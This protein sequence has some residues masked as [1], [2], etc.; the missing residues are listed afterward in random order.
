MRL[1][2]YTEDAE[3]GKKVP[4]NIDG[5]N[6]RQKVIGKI[7]V[8]VN[9]GG[10]WAIFRDQIVV[11]TSGFSAGGDSGSAVDKNGKFVGLLF[12]GSDTVTIV[13]ISK[14]WQTN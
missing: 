6:V 9:Y 8:K 1:W 12:A 13:N 2:F 5:I 11:S 14:K 4:K 7:T 10:N 3:K